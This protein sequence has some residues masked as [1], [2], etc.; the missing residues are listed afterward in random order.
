MGPNI[1]LKY[2]TCA[3]LKYCKLQDGELEVRI[4]GYILLGLKLCIIFTLTLGLNIVATFIMSSHGVDILFKRKPLS[5]IN[6]LIIKL[7]CTQTRQGTKTRPPCTNARMKLTF[8]STWQV[9]KHMVIQSKGQP[10]ETF[11]GLS[12]QK[13]H[14]SLFFNYMYHQNGN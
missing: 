2:P 3:T 9:R 14:L 8:L 1:S 13:G 11:H 4:R 7:T 5:D 12:D 6:Y 10:C